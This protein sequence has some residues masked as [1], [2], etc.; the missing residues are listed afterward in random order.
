[1]KVYPHIQGNTEDLQDL[2]HQHQVLMEMEVAVH[3]QVK[4]QLEEHPQVEIMVETLLVVI[5]IEK[6]TQLNT[7][8]LMM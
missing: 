5:V 1:M 7:I 8:P 4:D 6:D 2:Q 3:Q